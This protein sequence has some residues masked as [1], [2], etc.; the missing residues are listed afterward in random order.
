MCKFGC[1]TFNGLHLCIKNQFRLHLSCKGIMEQVLTGIAN[2]EKQNTDTI[3]Y[4]QCIQGR[5]TVA[6]CSLSSLSFSILCC[7]CCDLGHGRRELFFEEEN[8]KEDETALWKKYISK[9]EEVLRLIKGEANTR[10]IKGEANTTYEFRLEEM[11]LVWKG[12]VWRKVAI[13]AL[14]CVKLIE[15]R[16]SFIVR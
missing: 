12:Q 3:L 9:P 10:L 14:R 7:G 8:E 4:T 16:N 11:E 5:F 1:L 15:E 13:A 2:P 6:G